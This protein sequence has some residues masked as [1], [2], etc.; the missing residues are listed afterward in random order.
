MPLSHFT[1]RNAWE[2]TNAGFGYQQSNNY[3]RLIIGQIIE[4][5]YEYCQN[6]WQVFVVF[7]K[8]YDSVHR[9]SIYNIM[10]DFGFQKKKYNKVN[11]NVY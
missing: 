3:H 8:A 11:L 4:K 1:P 10:N 5:E 2:S 6:M 7:K 9:D